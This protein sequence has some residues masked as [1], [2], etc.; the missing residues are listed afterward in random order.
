MLQRNSDKTFT[1]AAI[2]L[3]E[4]ESARLLELLAT[5]RPEAE[6][7]LTDAVGRAAARRTSAPL[8]DLLAPA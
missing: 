1:V 8:G 7:A 3:D 2:N 4:E 6:K 5:P